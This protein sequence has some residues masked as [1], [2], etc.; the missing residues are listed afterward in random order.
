MASPP[1]K[2]KACLG[3]KLNFFPFRFQ[4]FHLNHDSVITAGPVVRS[5]LKGGHRLFEAPLTGWFTDNEVNGSTV[6]MGLLD[7][8]GSKNS[9]KGHFG[10]N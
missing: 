4:I 7:L 9:Y 8:C 1:N 6:T 2:N 3:G 5:P 10:D